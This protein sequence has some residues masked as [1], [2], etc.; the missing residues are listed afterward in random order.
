[1]SDTFY[2]GLRG[3]SAA[4]SASRYSRTGRV[5]DDSRSQLASLPGTPRWRLASALMMLA[6]MAKPSPPT[7]PSAFAGVLGHPGRENAGVSR[8]ETAAPRVLS[9]F[10]G[11]LSFTSTTRI[12]KGH[13]SCHDCR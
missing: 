6:S 3:C 12:S 7:G 4:S 11:T 13:L 5:S 9:H 2:G 10:A 8:G 1:M